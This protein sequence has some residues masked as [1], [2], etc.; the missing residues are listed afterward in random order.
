MKIDMLMEKIRINNS[1]NC[2]QYVQMYILLVGLIYN[3]ITY[4]NPPLK[5]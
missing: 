1:C 4:L 2:E 3:Y 5:I